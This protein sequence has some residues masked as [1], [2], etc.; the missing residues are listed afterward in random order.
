MRRIRWRG[1]EIIKPAALIDDEQIAGGCFAES[2]DLQRGARQLLMPCHLLAIM[3]DAPDAAGGPVAVNVCAAKLRKFA[4]VVNDA[5]GDRAHL[6]MR[7][8]DDGKDDCSRPA[9]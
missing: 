6:R 8:L 5:A 9:G 4:A 2:D 3:F 7:V 1:R